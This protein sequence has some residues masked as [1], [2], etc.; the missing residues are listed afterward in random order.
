MCKCNEALF[1]WKGCKI[2][3]NASRKPGADLKR[4]ENREEVRGKGKD[5]VF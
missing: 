5:E 3:K 4:V 2:G 1:S